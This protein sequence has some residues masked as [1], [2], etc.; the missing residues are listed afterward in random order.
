M[1]EGFT[2]L[3]HEYERHNLISGIKVARSAPPI[4]HIFCT[5]DCYI[6]CKENMES[7]EH[8]FDIL[9]VF[10]KASGQQI[11]VGKLFVFFSR[12]T[13]NILKQ[14]LCHRLKFQEANDIACTWV[15]LTWW[16]KGKLLCL[17][18]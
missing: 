11:N 10:V 14:K 1:I 9:Y 7:V 15:C 17:V 12:N 2:A 18:L 16:R 8:L 13:D 3:I 4:S 5:D 6:F